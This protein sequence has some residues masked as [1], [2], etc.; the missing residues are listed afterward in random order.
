MN[1]LVEKIIGNAF[2]PVQPIHSCQMSGCSGAGTANSSLGT[3][4]R[5]AP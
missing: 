1:V 3:A 2:T 4:L 5:G